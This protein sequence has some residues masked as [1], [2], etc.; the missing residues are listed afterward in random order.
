M[1]QLRKMCDIPIQNNINRKE[2][3]NRKLTGEENEKEQMMLRF[4]YFYYYFYY[5]F[6]FLGLLFVQGYP[7]L[8]ALLALQPTRFY[9][10][11]AYCC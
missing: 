11:S 6:F 4:Y 1:M 10:A 3:K 5:Y 9:R 8:G 2:Q 7:C